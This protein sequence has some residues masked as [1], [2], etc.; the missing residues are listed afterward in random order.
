MLT[1]HARS[2]D[3]CE[4]GRAEHDGRAVSERDVFDRVEHRQQQQAAQHALHHRAHAH[5]GRTEQAVGWTLACSTAFEDTEGQEKKELENK[6]EKMFYYKVK[7]FERKQHHALEEK[8]GEGP[9]K[10][11]RKVSDS[12]TTFS[13]L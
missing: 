8:N 2:E 5:A 9:N 3:E 4:D 6:S 11:F 10:I 7:S 12:I 1:Q 13:D